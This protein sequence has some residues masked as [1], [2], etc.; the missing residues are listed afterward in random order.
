MEQNLLLSHPIRK[1]R[2]V[3]V[4][5]PCPLGE[6]AKFPMPSYPVLFIDGGA[7]HQQHFKQHPSL[8]I[9]D[10]DSFSGHLDIVLP[11]EKNLSDLRAGLDLLPSHIEEI[12]F[13]GLIG[14]RKDHE[15][16][17]LGEIH[18]FLQRQQVPTQAYF[19]KDFQAIQKGTYHFSHQGIFSL[20]AL[21]E[22][23]VSLNGEIDYPLKESTPLEV[24]SSRGLS[25]Y[26]RGEFT[27][28]CDRPLFILFQGGPL[29]P[30]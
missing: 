26:A 2:K 19:D 20:I 16:I 4:V 1:T 21:Q 29:W 22:T 23:D 12:Y 17:N 10:G 6:A 7:A 24:L 15:M 14:G 18:H 13:L 25:N 30:K 27:I 28:S 9:G 11:K 3:I 8:S 5:G